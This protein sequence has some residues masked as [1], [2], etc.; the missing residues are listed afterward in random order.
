MALRRAASMLPRNRP[1]VG[2][3]RFFHKSLPAQS[4]LIKKDDVGEMLGKAHGNVEFVASK[5]DDLVNWARKGYVHSFLI[6][7]SYLHK[8]ICNHA[9]FALFSHPSQH[10]LNIFFRFD[11][12]SHI[13]YYFITIIT[14]ICV[15]FGT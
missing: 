2:Q 1:V 6:D 14:L 12:L 3:Q 5:V 7:D 8:Y 15:L 10:F 9:T 13:R 4:E 11:L